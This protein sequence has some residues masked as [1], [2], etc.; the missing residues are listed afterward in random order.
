MVGHIFHD[1][2]AILSV[3]VRI[4]ARVGV[5]VGVRVRVMVR[6]G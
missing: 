6:E 3:D 4:M 2:P 5:R 1:A